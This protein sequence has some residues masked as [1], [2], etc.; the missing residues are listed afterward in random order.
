MGNYPF[1]AIGPMGL[2][3]DTEM[4]HITKLIFKWV[5]WNLLLTGT[6]LGYPNLQLEGKRLDMLKK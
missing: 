5:Y 3:Q 2:L 6:W 1:P 4:N